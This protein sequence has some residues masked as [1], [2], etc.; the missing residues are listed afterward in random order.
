MSFI[1]YAKSV[2][3]EIS[4]TMIFAR[5]TMFKDSTFGD[6]AHWY[7]AQSLAYTFVEYCCEKNRTDS[8]LT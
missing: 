3:D 8:K 5:L 6:L 7:C 1:Q 4:D 2:Y